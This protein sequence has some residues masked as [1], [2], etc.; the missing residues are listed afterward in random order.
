MSLAFGIL[1]LLTYKENTGY[2][3]TKIFEDSLNNFWHAQ[4]SQIYRELNRMEK[5]GLVASR[6]IIQDGRPNK[7]LYSI[8]DAGRKEFSEWLCVIKPGFENPHDGM[9]MRIFFGADNP[10]ETL[11]ALRQ[12]RE[13]YLK[14]LEENC[15]PIRGNIE[16]Y[17]RMIPDG[18]E[19]SRYWL[20]TLE[21]GVARARATAEWAERCIAQIEEGRER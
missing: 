12:C 14:A 2:D 21:L 1:G 15:S 4:S 5:E 11:A 16:K 8:T 9:L 10:E 18:R 20:M 17:A 7:R 13:Q 19:K 3:L 6:S